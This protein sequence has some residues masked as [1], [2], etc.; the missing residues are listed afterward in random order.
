MSTS[1]NWDDVEIVIEGG[2]LKGKGFS[3][4]DAVYVSPKNFLGK[5][6][7][8]RELTPQ[9]VHRIKIPEYIPENMNITINITQE[10]LERMKN[11]NQRKIHNKP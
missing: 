11:E 10:E 2:K 7:H 8:E 3:V 5:R 6:L 4:G 1:F 9:H